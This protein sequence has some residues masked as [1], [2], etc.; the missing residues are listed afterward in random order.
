MHIVSEPILQH[1]RDQ[2]PQLRPTEHEHDASAVG[3]TEEHDGSIMIL[4][5]QDKELWYIEYVDFKG[6]TVYTKPA[7]FARKLCLLA[8]SFG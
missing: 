1:R 7:S 3:S 2:T 8:R 4:S 5:E 6:H